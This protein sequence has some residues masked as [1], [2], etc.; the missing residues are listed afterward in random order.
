MEQRRLQ[1]DALRQVRTEFHCLRFHGG[2][3]TDKPTATD[4]SESVN[5]SLLAEF[6]AWYEDQ[7][8]L[9]SQG[10]ANDVRYVALQAWLE[11]RR[12]CQ[13][14]TGTRSETRLTPEAGRSSPAGALAEGTAKNGP[15]DGTA[16][17]G[18]LASAERVATGSLGLDGW[19]IYE[20]RKAEEKNS[21][22]TI[23]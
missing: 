11:S 18:S 5:P 21:H 17:A 10:H 16:P 15:G 19:P 8:D 23:R 2:P 14:T 20:T 9:P 1:P 4:G 13:V 7:P 22:W 12:R 3:V 6:S